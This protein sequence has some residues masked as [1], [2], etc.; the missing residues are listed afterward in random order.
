[1]KK[2]VLKRISLLIAPILILLLTTFFMVREV[3]NHFYSKNEQ[4]VMA[5]LPDV[6]PFNTLGYNDNNI[7][8]NFLGIIPIKSVMVN[9]VQDIEVIPG[10]RSIGIRL[11]SKG[12]LVVGYSEVN[13]N[14]EKVESPGKL[15][16]IEIGDLIISVNDKNVD[17]TK[18][19]IQLIKATKEDSIE[20]EIL[21]N[22]EKLLK[23][24]K[25]IKENNKDAKI[26]LWIRDTTAGVGTLTFTDE[27]TGVFG[28]LGH[29]VTDGDTNKLFNIRE[30]DLL[31]SSVISIR[32]GESGS[33][34]ELKGIFIDGNNSLGKI[35]QNTQCGIF[36]TCKDVKS[37]NM[38]G[39][40]VK[41]GFRDEIT[42]GKASIIT[43]IDENGP[44][45]YD[46]EIIKLFQQKE[47]GPKSMLIKIT[48]EELLQKTGGIVQGMSGSP[49][50]QNGKMIGA[51]THV[52]INKPDVGYG[53]YI[54]WMLENAGIL[55]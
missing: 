10:G 1:M 2:R 50:M 52:L 27:K 31:E 11:S 23:E 34:G 26:G 22:E 36:G 5:L 33:P 28:A 16:G 8:I 43:T 45:E 3:P 48:D 21:R 14:N 54:D 51:V 24:L 20:L 25:I 38:R 49:I 18:N 53:I 55:K 37:F 40:K 46:I 12:V 19:L 29:P 4:S 9:K 39:E 13:V 6:G 32:K 15:A 30:G 44:K 7:Q 41:I 35:E 47:A 42:I 17:S